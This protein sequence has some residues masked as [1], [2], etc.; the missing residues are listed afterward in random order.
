MCESRSR[1]VV[2][3]VQYV[4]CVFVC[5][6][7]LFPSRRCFTC[8]LRTCFTPRDASFHLDDDDGDDHAETSEHGNSMLMHFKRNGF[9]LHRFRGHSVVICVSTCLCVCE[10]FMNVSG[11][12]FRL[13]RGGNRIKLRGVREIGSMV[14]W[15]PQPQ[16]FQAGWEQKLGRIGIR[17][18]Q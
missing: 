10:Q 1:S 9:H 4:V 15:R 11:L 12:T 7:S 2:S 8:L 14:L 17:R 3:A 13:P 18:V 6:P 5:F 16:P